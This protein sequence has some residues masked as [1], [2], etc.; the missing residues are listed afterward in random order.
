MA[1]GSVLPSLVHLL[2]ERVAESR[3]R[4]AVI[5]REQRLTYGELQAAAHVLA[6]RLT[7]LGI[8]PGDRVALMA[9]NVPAFAVGYFGILSAGAIVVPLNPLLKPEEVRYAL[10]D[11]GAAAI[12]GLAMSG[13]LLLEAREGI[14][15]EVPL[16]LLDATS[17]RPELPLSGSGGEPAWTK[18]V[19]AP[20]VDREAVAVCLYTSGTTGRP[21]GAL[22]T[23]GNILANIESFRQVLRLT[24]Q[25]VFL[26]VLPLFHAYGATVMFLEPL[27]V[28]APIVLEARF[29]PELLLKSI[30]EHRV[31]IFSGV[32]S[33][34]TVLA[35][36]PKPPGDYSAWRLCLSGGAPLPPAV[37]ERFEQQHG[38][39]IYEGYGPTECAPVLTVNPPSGLRK[40]GSVGPPIPGVELRVVGEDDRPLPVGHVGEIVARGA[41][42]MRG[43]FNRPAETAE[44]LRGG[45]YHTGDLGWTDEEGYYR[46]VDRKVD[47]IIVGGLNVYPS[48]VEAVLAQHPAVQAVAVVGLPDPVR[49]EVPRAVVVPQNGEKPSPQELIQWCRQRLANYKVPRSVVFATELPRSVT[50]KVLKGALREAG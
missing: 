30:A 12:L 26:T 14:G 42:V 35:A 38:V 8:A 40:I 31:T 13:P 6:G 49:G 16:I 15:R 43:Y 20:T 45:W 25:D 21:K 10:T 17:G 37:L 34:F 28:G 23:H 29:Q 50:G 22:L 36:T 27:A 2:A 11:S 5:C 19:A 48:E 44:A 32:P 9:P 41:N 7:S 1:E 33:M 18:P 24:E 3:D 4:V 47:M 46:I 39:L